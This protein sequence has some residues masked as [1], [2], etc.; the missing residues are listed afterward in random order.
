MRAAGVAMARTCFSPLLDVLDSCRVEDWFAV[1]KR[2]GETV[3]LEY[4]KKV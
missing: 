4:S 2:Q 3:E 1:A